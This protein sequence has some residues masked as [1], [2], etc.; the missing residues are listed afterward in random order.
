ML[1][2]V[3]GREAPIARSSSDLNGNFRH[4]VAAAK[5]ADRSAWMFFLG[6]GHG[7]CRGV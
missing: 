3:R 4:V 7:K 1:R 2:L 6:T 5:I